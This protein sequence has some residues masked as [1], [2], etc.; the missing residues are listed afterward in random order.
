VE[1]VA[2]ALSIS[3][4]GGDPEEFSK[5]KLKEEVAEEYKKGA[6]RKIAPKDRNL[7]SEEERDSIK[8][9][10]KKKKL[11]EKT[12]AFVEKGLHGTNLK[13]KRA[14][15]HCVCYLFC[16]RWFCSDCFFALNEILSDLTAFFS[17]LKHCKM[18]GR[19]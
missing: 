4:D 18:L 10:E 2:E 19:V 3:L 7:L 13:H 11:I 9:E 1:S 5:E 17:F 15:F 8:R 14:V 12:K 6:L 16:R